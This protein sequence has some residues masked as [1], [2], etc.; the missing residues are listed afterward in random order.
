[1]TQEQDDNANQTG[2]RSAIPIARQLDAVVILPAP[3]SFFAD[4]FVAHCTNT[5]II[6]ASR[7]QVEDLQRPGSQS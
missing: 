2:A 6:S 4:M 1:M 5:K 3:E 7:D